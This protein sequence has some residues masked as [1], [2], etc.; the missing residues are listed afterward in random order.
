MTPPPL[1]KA[2]MKVIQHMAGNILYYSHAINPTMLLALSIIATQQAY[3]MQATI[4]KVK[5][6]LHYCAL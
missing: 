6:F 3:P 4:D 2:D 5:H 1:V